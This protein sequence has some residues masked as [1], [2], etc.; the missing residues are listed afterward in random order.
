MYERRVEK[1]VYH[2]LPILSILGK[3]QVVPVG[4]T[5]TISFSQRQHA[6]EF[7]MRHSTAGRAPE[8]AAGGGISMLVP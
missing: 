6:E 3:L 5:G 8:T 7:V 4:D 1:Q 2:V